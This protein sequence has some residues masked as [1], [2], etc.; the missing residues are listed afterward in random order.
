MG[1]TKLPNYGHLML[2]PTF[3]R[4]QR[5]DGRN[6]DKKFDATSKFFV[7]HRRTNILTPRSGLNHLQL[8]YFSKS[9]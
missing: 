1:R 5:P 7:K 8:D 2:Y 9:A 6:I 3:F 4:L